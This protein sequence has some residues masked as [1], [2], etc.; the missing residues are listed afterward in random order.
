MVRTEIFS[1]STAA[2][3]SYISAEAVHHVDQDD[4]GLTGVGDHALELG[5]LVR[6]S[7]DGIVAILRDDAVAFACAPF[8]THAQLVF[9]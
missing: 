9:D 4:A 8:A 7:R 1:D 5:A 6:L 2:R 3:P